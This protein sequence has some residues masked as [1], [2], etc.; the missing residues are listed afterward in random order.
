M[1]E[2]IQISKGHTTTYC[3]NNEFDWW[4]LLRQLY[5]MLKS[6]KWH[7][8][9][10]RSQLGVIRIMLIYAFKY[11]SEIPLRI[12]NFLFVS[13]WNQTIM[14]LS[15]IHEPQMIACCNSH[16]VNMVIKYDSWLILI[17]HLTTVIDVKTTIILYAYTICSHVCIASLW[18]LEKS[19][20]HENG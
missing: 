19:H 1:C 16:A 2:S 6:V 10:L 4:S 3:Q 13:K 20:K 14:L 7:L 18:G 17:C 15:V 11:P 9:S 8:I 5:S 12:C